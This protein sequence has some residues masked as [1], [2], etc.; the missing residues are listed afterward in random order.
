MR[1]QT[2]NWTNALQFAARSIRW[3]WLERKM[4]WK[5]SSFSTTSQPTSS[6]RRPLCKRLKTATWTSSSNRM[7]SSNNSQAWPNRFRSL[8]RSPRE[9]RDPPNWAKTRI[10]TTKELSFHLENL[11]MY[12]NQET[13]PH[14]TT[15]LSRMKVLRTKFK[16]TGSKV[17]V[18]REPLEMTNCSVI[19]TLQRKFPTSCTQFRVWSTRTIIR[20]MGDWVRPPRHSQTFKILWRATLVQLRMETPK[21]NWQ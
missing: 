12:L 1:N 14:T 15:S 6:T 16:R 8:F 10:R 17:P 2:W 13:T 7:T 20:R 18:A 21:T 4:I 11:S 19:T 5:T 9:S 3:Q